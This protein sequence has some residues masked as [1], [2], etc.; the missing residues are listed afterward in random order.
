MKVDVSTQLSCSA[1]KAWN[2]VQRSSLMVRVMRP[3]IR[4]APVDAS[5]LPELWMEGR[6]FRCRLFVFGF[7][8]IG[9]RALRFERIDAAA[10]EIRTHESDP[11]VRRWDHRISIQPA[12][13]RRSV[14]RDEIEIDAGALSFFVWAFANWFYRH[15]QARWRKIAQSL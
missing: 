8:P 10:R 13:E 12:G 2:E 1:T 7:I 15:R 6:Q 9:V 3:L 4:V 5:G 14:Y 11:L